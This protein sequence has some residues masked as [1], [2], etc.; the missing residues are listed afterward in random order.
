MELVY[1]PLHGSNLFLDALP[2]A[3]NDTYSGTR[4]QAC[5]L[6]VQPLITEFKTAKPQVNESPKQFSARLERYL[7]RWIELAKVDKDC[8]KLKNFVVRQQY[9]GSCTVQ[10]A[11]FLTKWKLADLDETALTAEQYKDAHTVISAPWYNTKC[12]IF[13]TNKNQT[14]TMG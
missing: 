6:E 13:F 3:T 5:W 9:P 14:K 4:T 2:D 11:V 8:D 10:L 1:T 12:I 7:M